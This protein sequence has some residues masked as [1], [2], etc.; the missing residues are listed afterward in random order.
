MKENAFEITGGRPLSGIITPQ[1]AK[2][3]ALQVLCTCLLTSEPVTFH[4]VPDII[5]VNLLIELLEA[6]NVQ[7]ARPQK[8]TVVL[9][10]ADPDLEFF[11]S[12]EFKKKSGKLR[13]AVMMAGP[14]LARYGKAQIPQPGGS[15]ATARRKSRS[16]A[17][18]KLVAAASTP[19][20]WVSKNSALLFGSTI[21]KTCLASKLKAD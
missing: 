7:V 12:P 5:D 1:G 14:L 13:G 10:A 11:S 18:I 16:R 3:E 4:N 21:P 9:Q 17:A 8:G 6:M 2:N 15:P 19:T 20:F